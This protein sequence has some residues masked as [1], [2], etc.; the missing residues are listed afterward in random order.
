MSVWM[1]VMKPHSLRRSLATLITRCSSWLGGT[2]NWKVTQANCL[3]QLA[4]H[5]A[6]VAGY[7]YNKHITEDNPCFHWLDVK[8]WKKTHCVREAERVVFNLHSLSRCDLRGCFFFSFLGKKKDL[9]HVV[10]YTVCLANYCFLQNSPLLLKN[11]GVKLLFCYI[12]K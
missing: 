2:F 8:R 3:F 7:I 4:K 1:Y 9:W 6:I 11:T 12:L 5:C 10:L